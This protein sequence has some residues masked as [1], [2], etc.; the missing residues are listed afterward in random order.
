MFVRDARWLLQLAQSPATDDVGAYFDVALKVVETLPAQDRIEIHKA[1]VRMTAG[2]LRSQIRYYSTKKAVP[3]DEKSLV[4]NT[5]TS[6]ALDFALLIQ[7]LVPLLKAYEHAWRTGD[8]RKRLELAG[9]ICQ[10]IAADAELFVNRVALLSAYSMI[11]YL[12]ITTNRDG[13]LGYTPMGQRHVQRL[14]RS[15]VAR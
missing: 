3:F 5:R 8:D 6:N 2:H 13:Q 12:F 15:V 9:A 7:E 4:L 1:G 10:G 11:E 14:G